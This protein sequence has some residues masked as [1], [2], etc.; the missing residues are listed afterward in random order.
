MSH[1]LNKNE[2][3][4]GE[5][6]KGLSE[7]VFWKCNDKYFEGKIILTNFKVNFFFLIIF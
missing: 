2:I 5:E 1:G 6:F 3:E 7:N 4:E